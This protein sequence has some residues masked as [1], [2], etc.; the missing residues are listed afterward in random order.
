MGKGS[1]P[2]PY[3]VSQNTFA[4]NWKL[5]FGKRDPKEREDAQIEDE[6]FE[7]INKQKEINERT[8][9]GKVQTQDNQ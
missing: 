3:S 9:D 5:A 1:T 8:V 2:R 4:S 6:A 7:S